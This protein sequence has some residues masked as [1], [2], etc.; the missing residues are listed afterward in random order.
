MMIKVRRWRL[1]RRSR[2]SSWKHVQGELVFQEK[3]LW[4]V[5]QKLQRVTRLSG[6]MSLGYPESV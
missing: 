1:M 4:G 5:R 3:A 2:I 6:E